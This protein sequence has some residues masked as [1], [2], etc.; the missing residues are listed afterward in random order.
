MGK[1][2]R[3]NH[4]PDEELLGQLRDLKKQ[5]KQKDQWIRQLEKDLL[6]KSPQKERRRQQKEILCVECGKGELSLLDIGIRKYT[7]CNLCKDRKRID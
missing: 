6:L 2:R 7:I 5:L 1:E 4:R 3:K